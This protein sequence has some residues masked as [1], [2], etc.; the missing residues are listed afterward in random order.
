MTLED[1]NNLHCV[2]NKPN[3]DMPADFTRLNLRTSTPI[4]LGAIKSISLATQLETD[5]LFRVELR[6]RFDLA[7]EYRADR[8]EAYENKIYV[9]ETR[10]E[11]E[12]YYS[13]NVFFF[14]QLYSAL[15]YITVYDK[16]FISFSTPKNG[17]A[18]CGH[19]NDDIELIVNIKVI[20]HVSHAVLSWHKDSH[21]L[22]NMKVSH[23][24]NININYTKDLN[25]YEAD[26]DSEMSHVTLNIKNITSDD[27]GIILCSRTSKTVYCRNKRIL[28]SFESH[29]LTCTILSNQLPIISWYFFKCKSFACESHE[30]KITKCK[31]NGEMH[32]V[33]SIIKGTKSEASGIYRCLASN[34]NGFN[35]VDKRFIVTTAGSEGFRIEVNSSEI[36]EGD[37]ILLTCQATISAHIN[38][39]WLIKSP[40]NTLYVQIWPQST[41]HSTLETKLLLL[42]LIHRDLAARNILVA[43]Q[44]IVKIC[45][46]GLARDI[47]HEYNYKTKSSTRLPIKWMTIESI[48]DQ[49]FTSKSDVWSFG[50]LLW[51][52]FSLGA[53]PY[54]GIDFDQKLYAQLLHGYRMDRPDKCPLD[55]Y[56]IMTDCWKSQPIER[57]DFGQLVDKLS[58]LMD[59]TIVNYYLDLNSSYE[60]V[61]KILTS[62]EYD[63]DQTRYAPMIRSIQ[64]YAV[65]NSVGKQINRPENYYYNTSSDNPVNG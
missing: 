28:F 11:D 50:I 37:D 10:I 64:G 34:T 46:F 63:T 56:Y 60:E 29:N 42:S 25:K 33:T 40:Q 39:V 18:L 54:P 22:L 26:F 7:S 58:K 45:E 43:E 41:I 15:T 49:V 32:S 20:P 44:K 17:S 2:V 6:S 30:T 53:T 23:G 24:N 52:I 59:G 14:N 21:R 1:A 47:Q 57:P 61:N 3:S 16:V 36:V 8:I 12:G 4:K 62:E 55:I 5:N 51:E 38:L 35:Y 31:P 65:M 13:F 9:Y 48:G 19:E 27:M